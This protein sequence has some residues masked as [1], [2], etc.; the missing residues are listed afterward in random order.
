MTNIIALQIQAKTGTKLDNIPVLRWMVL[1]GYVV[2]QTSLGEA[3]GVQ[4]KAKALSTGAEGDT[5]IDTPTDTNAKE[6]M[7]SKEPKPAK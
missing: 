1:V 4:E 5:T 3:Q 2:E 7:P 6:V